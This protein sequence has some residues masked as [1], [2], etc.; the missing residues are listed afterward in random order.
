ME[1]GDSVQSHLVVVWAQKKCF[2]FFLLSD[3]YRVVHVCASFVMAI[4]MA[5]RDG[6]GGGESHYMGGAG[7][8]HAYFIYY[9]CI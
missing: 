7:I 5:S 2:K 4:D 6:S 8:V 3:T 1:G 9:I